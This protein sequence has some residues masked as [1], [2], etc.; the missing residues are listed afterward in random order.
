MFG[1]KI[2][3]IGSVPEWNTR[4]LEQPVAAWVLTEQPSPAQRAGLGTKSHGTKVNYQDLH[5]PED[6]MDG[7]Q[8]QVLPQHR[9]L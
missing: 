2:A 5:R 7:I 9:S 1:F 6:V 3:Q 4:L 8:L